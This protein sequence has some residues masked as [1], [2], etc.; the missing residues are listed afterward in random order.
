MAADVDSWR[1]KFIKKESSASDGS[2]YEKVLR[3]VIDFILIVCLLDVYLDC[4]TRL[5]N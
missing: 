5:I 4:T 2:S 1:L 3:R